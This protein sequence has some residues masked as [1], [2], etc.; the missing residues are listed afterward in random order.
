MNTGTNPTALQCPQCG[1]PL[2]PDVE[3]HTVCRYCGT[4]LVWPAGSAGGAIVRG[5]HLKPFA[6]VDAEG[7]GLEVFRMLVPVGWQS[8]GG[9]RWLL[10]NPGM[11]ATIAFQLWNPQGAELFEILPSMNFIWNS[12]GM[13]APTGSRHFGA[14]VAPPAG[15]RDALR[16]LVLPRYR[17]YA[18][19]LQIVAEEP[20]PDLPRLVRSEAAITGGSA[21]G[22]RARVRYA[23]QGRQYEEDLFGVV[24]VFRAPAA[25]L[26]G[27][28]EIIIWFVDYLFSFRAAAG[29]L[30]G[31]R[32]LF[33]VLMASFRANPQWNA[34]FKSIAQ[35][36]AQQQ[37]QHIRN[38]G[39]IGQMLAQ[40]GSEAREQNLRDWYAHQEIY[41]RLTT[42]W[43]RVTRGVDAFVDPYRQ[44]VVELP[45][46][47]G[48]A[49]ANNLGEYVLTESADFNPNVGSNLQWEPMR[50][51]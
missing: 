39:Q 23:W 33:T 25:S 12:G 34:A 11:P 46:G 50:P 9:C 41:D 6:C 45:A 27:P 32:N 49:W 16:G 51:G 15:I 20:Q 3:G 2:A 5:V 1:A 13:M 44:E 4:S 36:L 30:D 28:S 22:G 19:Q 7:T 40:A 35:F 8:R 31:A 42:D 18:E 47:Y 37:I 38:V 43:G 26:F 48:H 24:E 21:E 14:E 10:D 17:S 29:R